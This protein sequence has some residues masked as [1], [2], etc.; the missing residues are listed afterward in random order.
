MPNATISLWWACK[1]FIWHLEIGGGREDEKSSP[2]DE[3]LFFGFSLPLQMAQK[4]Q[5]SW[6]HWQKYS[7]LVPWRIKVN[8]EAFPY[9]YQTNRF[10]PNK[11]VLCGC[12]LC[13]INYVSW[14]KILTS[15]Q[16]LF[17]KYLQT[18]S[19]VSDTKC[20]THLW[21][22]TTVTRQLLHMIQFT[23][24]VRYDFFQKYPLML[25]CIQLISR[26]N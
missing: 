12:Q 3:V 13:S 22:L 19:Q 2:E 6:Y 23:C 26:T 5:Y 14:Y 17:L 24:L 20:G 1:D 9:Q 18:L 11:K 21:L 15:N 25:S 7:S 10:S 16:W 4:T 8:L